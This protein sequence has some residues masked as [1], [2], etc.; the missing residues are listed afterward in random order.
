MFESDVFVLLI[1][2]QGA[3]AGVPPEDR[4]PVLCGTERPLLWLVCAAGQVSTVP[5][6]ANVPSKQGAAPLGLSHRRNTSPA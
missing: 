6:I 2:H 1:D 5:V 3:S 4:L